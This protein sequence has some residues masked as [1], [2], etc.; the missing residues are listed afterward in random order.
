MV[1]REW[2]HV[3]VRTCDQDTG[4]WT[5]DRLLS[6]SHCLTASLPSMP[7]LHQMTGLCKSRSGASKLSKPCKSC[8]ARCLVIDDDKYEGRRCSRCHDALLRRS[9]LWPL[10][11]L[12]EAPLI[13][14]LAWFGFNFSGILT[15]FWP[16]CHVLKKAQ[17]RYQ[18]LWNFSKDENLRF[19]SAKH[20]FLS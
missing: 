9:S 3:C 16:S 1:S 2:E 10:W 11:H 14:I 18:G 12:L 13:F 8:A 17:L 15:S 19:S 5:L 4:H 20:Y 7:G 6:L